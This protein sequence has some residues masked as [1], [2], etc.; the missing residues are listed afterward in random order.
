MNKKILTAFMA[1]TVSAA[2]VL[3]A[4]NASA[5]LNDLSVNHSND[6]LATTEAVSSGEISLTISSLAGNT[7][8]TSKGNFTASKSFKQSLLQ[9]IVR[10]F[11][12]LKR[13]LL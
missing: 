12:M 8:R 1:T 3:P 13:L 10:P 9:Q 11:K 2:I 6:L 7:V 5:A 4:P